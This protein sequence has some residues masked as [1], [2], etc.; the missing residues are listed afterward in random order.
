V[1]IPTAGKMKAWSTDSLEASG[2]RPGQIATFF[3]EG[4]DAA[5]IPGA[6]LDRA[7]IMLA[8]TFGAHEIRAALSTVSGTAGGYA[9]TPQS[10]PEA[11][12][13]ALQ[14]FPVRRLAEVIRT[15]DAFKHPWPMAND[16][17]QQGAILPEG[18]S[19]TAAD[20]SFTLDLLQAYKI[21]SQ[22]LI[23]PFELLQ[24][25]GRVFGEMF[26]MRVLS[27]RI[28]RAQNF[29]FTVGTGISQPEGVVPAAPV[30]VTS[31]SSTLITS[32][33]V[34]SLAYAV[35]PIYREE[36]GACYMMNPT[37]LKL[38]AELKDAN[39]RSIFMNPQLPGLPGM[40]GR[41]PVVENPAMG[42]SVTPGQKLILFGAFSHYKVREVRETY[43]TVWR[44]AVGLI[45][46]DLFAAAA[47]LRCDGML[48]DP[49]NGPVV[50]LQQHAI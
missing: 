50:A 24:D 3:R 21:D 25:A 41:Y 28:A 10:A 30:A 22:K 40:I 38:V 31:G 6:G 18:G 1:L 42:T 8:D 23:F 43:L 26:V 12:E 39:G 9:V 36:P 15:D 4:G 20:V 7:S 27:Q 44:E 17:T 14:A 19:R 35:D 16:T 37:T 2:L 46:N 49:G 47:T 34:T 32:D 45:E 11:V 33:E 29:Y 48:V 5:G 13:L